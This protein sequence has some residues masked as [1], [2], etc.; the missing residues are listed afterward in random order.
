[1]KNE[2]ITSGFSKL[3]RN[4]KIDLIFSELELD[5]AQKN[6]LDSFLLSNKKIQKLLSE[7]SENHISN[8]YL[9]Y[10]IIPNVYINEKKYFVPMVVEE[11]SVVAAAARSAKFWA[12]NGGFQAKIINNKKSGQVHFLWHENPDLL[13]SVFPLL[14]EEIVENL[15]PLTERM[16]QRGGGILAIELVDKSNEI[17]H[18]YQ[19]DVL[20]DTVDAMG[21]NFIN[22]CLENIATTMRGFFNHP[23]NLYGL[24]PS[25]EIIMSILSNYYKDCIVECSVEGDVSLFSH[26]SQQLTGEDFA[27]RFKLAVDIA[28]LDISRAVTHNK[29]IYNGVDAVALAT[30]NDWRAIEASGHAFASRDGKYRSLTQATLDQNYFKYTLTLPIAM[31]S[32]GGL[33]NLHPLAKISMAILENPSAE[34]LMKIAAAA[35]LANNFSAIWSLITSGIQK[36]HMKLHLSNILNQLGV[37]YHLHDIVSQFFENKTVSYSSVEKYINTELIKHIS[38]A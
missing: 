19:I 24:K 16:E 4:Q 3:S 8:F 18:Y 21:A 17:E 13:K 7:I 1:M 30:G 22:S 36:G 6:E 12:K 15:L 35:G 31:G 37:D 34:D 28:N 11:S 14:K 25:Y 2:R 9:P 32:V 10:S 5:D 38:K 29:G 33:T 20:F 27:R 23:K 26:A